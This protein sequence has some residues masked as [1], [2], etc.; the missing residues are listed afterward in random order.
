MIDKNLYKRQLGGIAPEEAL[1]LDTKRKM[2]EICRP[3]GR[4][5]IIVLL[6][7][8]AGCLVLTLAAGA[9]LPGRTA[10]SDGDAMLSGEEPEKAAS[11]EAG[12]ADGFAP[13]FASVTAS[14]VPGGLLS[15]SVIEKDSGEF[16]QI[17]EKDIFLTPVFGVFMPVTMLKGYKFESCYLYGEDETD[18]S[19]SVLYSAGHNYVSIKIHPEAPSDAIFAAAVWDEDSYDITRHPIPHSGTIPKDSREVTSSPI[20]KAE[21]LTSRALELRLEDMGGDAGGG[22]RMEFGV[23]C[24]DYIV[25]Y[26]IRADGMDGIFEMVTSAERFSGAV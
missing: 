22:Y 18:M 14:Q 4:A 24:G 13:V 11:A 25:R 7:L 12:D 10:G 23:D 3:P 2:S 8:L 26:V 20:F 17:S 19:F 21:E 1:V 6:A 16:T 5:G 15:D 9:L